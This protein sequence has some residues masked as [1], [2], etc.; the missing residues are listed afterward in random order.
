MKTQ[1]S[2]TRKF[3]VDEVRDRLRTNDESVKRALLTLYLRQT[4]D[5]RR[6]KDTKHD[7]NVG[8][9]VPDSYRLTSFGE[10]LNRTGYLS[11][12]QVAYVRPRLLKYSR[13]LLEIYEGKR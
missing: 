1:Q 7:N 2:N 6:D 4:S 8:F 10:F 5:E 9:N 12:K 13:Q 11:P 3:T